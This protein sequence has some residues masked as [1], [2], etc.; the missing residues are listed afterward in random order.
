MT[1]VYSAA[2][3]VRVMNESSPPE[4]TLR[5]KP[6]ALTRTDQDGEVSVIDDGCLESRTV[7]ALPPAD[8]KRV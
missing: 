2:F 1:V 8:A 5:P 4:P 7:L 3:V 6:A